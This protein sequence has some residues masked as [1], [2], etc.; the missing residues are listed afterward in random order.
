MYEAPTLLMISPDIREWTET[1]DL[2]S[3]QYGYRVLDVRTVT[4]AETVFA[5]VHVDLVISEENGTG[6]GL[7]FLSDLRTSSSPAHITAS[8][9]ILPV[10]NV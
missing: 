2:L 8:N 1:L 5:G 4:D 10:A 9:T 7:S 6:E 3:G